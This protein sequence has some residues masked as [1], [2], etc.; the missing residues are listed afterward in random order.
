MSKGKLSIGTIAAAALMGAAFSVAPLNSA[1]AGWWH[2]HHHHHHFMSRLVEAG[3]VSY[4]IYRVEHYT[5]DY[6]SPAYTY[7]GCGSCGGWFW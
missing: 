3:S 2:H 5:V 4:P 1:Q 6:S 7:T